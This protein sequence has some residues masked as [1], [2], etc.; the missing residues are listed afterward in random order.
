MRRIATTGSERQLQVVGGQPVE[1]LPEFGG[2]TPLG[3]PGQPAELA[4]AYVFL[5]SQ[6]SSNITGETHFRHRGCP[7]V[8][9][10]E[11]GGR[12]DY[13]GMYIGGEGVRSV[14]CPRTASSGLG[15]RP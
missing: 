10:D 1:K 14:P 12:R 4:P 9:S 2:Q 6:E 13:R 11:G 8:A 15:R 5:A 3:R 7:H